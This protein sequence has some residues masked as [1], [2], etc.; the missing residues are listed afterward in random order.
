MSNAMIANLETVSRDQL[1]AV[2][3]GQNPPMGQ[4][5]PAKVD[6]KDVADVARA[7]TKATLAPVTLLP[8]IPDAIHRVT[9]TDRVG[10]NLSDRL[11]D[12][13]TGLFGIDPLAKR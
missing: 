11:L 1:M 3:G 6:G 4:N 7:A 2:H 12:G 13:F 10:P 8:N 9:R 5:P